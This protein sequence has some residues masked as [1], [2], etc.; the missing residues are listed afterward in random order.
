QAAAEADRRA[1]GLR[2]HRRPRRVPVAPLHAGHGRDPGPDRRAAF[3]PASAAGPLCPRGLRHPGVLRLFQPAAGVEGLDGA[4]GRAG[5]AGHVVGARPVHRH[6]PG[7]VV[8]VEG[9][10]LLDRYL[11]RTILLYS[12]LVMSVLLVLGGLFLFVGQQND[13]GVGSY[14]TADAL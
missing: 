6:R 11:I 14:S 7:G 3:A 9:M 5:V 12:A 1:A 13:I 8:A 10:T 2:A 4:R